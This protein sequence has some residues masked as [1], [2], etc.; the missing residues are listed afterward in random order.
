MK[1]VNQVKV[2]ASEA[3]AGKYLPVEFGTNK[4]VGKDSVDRIANAN[5]KF[6]LESLEGDLSRFSVG[7]PV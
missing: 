4:V 6:G 5:F 2:F 7:I 1:R 3:A